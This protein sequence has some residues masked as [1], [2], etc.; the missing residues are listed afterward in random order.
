MSVVIEQ[1]FSNDYCSVLLLGYVGYCG[2]RAAG[3]E[4]V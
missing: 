4:Q 1:R 3:G 2:A